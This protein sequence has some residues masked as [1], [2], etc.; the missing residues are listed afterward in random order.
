KTG[1][2]SRV[3]AGVT[4]PY[5]QEDVDLTSIGTGIHQFVKY[6]KQ[7]CINYSVVDANIQQYYDIDT[8]EYTIQYIRAFRI[9]YA[10]ILYNTA[11]NVVFTYHP[12]ALSDSTERYD[13]ETTCFTKQYPGNLIWDP[14]NHPKQT[15]DI[16]PYTPPFLVTNFYNPTAVFDPFFV[17]LK[18]YKIGNDVL[19]QLGK[20]GTDRVASIHLRWFRN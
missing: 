12:D 11:I 17:R 2:V 19:L 9:H 16:L 3:V 1:I 7:T 15:G 8:G 20:S 4:T 10:S 5:T 18:P 6:S 13:Y 14:N